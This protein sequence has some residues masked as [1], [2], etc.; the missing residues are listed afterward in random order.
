MAT[1]SVRAWGEVAKRVDPR[2]RIAFSLACKTFRQ[3]LREANERGAI[4]TDL[5]DTL[6]KGSH[7]FS[8]GWFKW[9]YE[10]F[11]HPREGGFGIGDGEGREEGCQLGSRGVV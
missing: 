7:C 1:V 2:D 9:V 8:L 3:A 11:V 6:S 10:T 5:S 4:V